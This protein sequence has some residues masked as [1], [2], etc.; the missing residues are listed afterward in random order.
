MNFDS[1][2]RRLLESLQVDFDG[3]L[4]AATNLY[5][6]IGL[7]SLQAF[8]LVVLIEA[9]AGL[10]ITP[11]EIPEIYTLADAYSYYCLAQELA[12]ADDLLS[13]GESRDRV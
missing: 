2:S 4:S 12:S 9:W 7:D 10:M 11:Q 5:E 6:E 8:E 3:Q 13:F 1:F